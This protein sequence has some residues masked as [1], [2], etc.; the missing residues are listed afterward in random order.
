MHNKTSVVAYSVRGDNHLCSRHTCVCNQNLCDSNSCEV[1]QTKQIVHKDDK[2][3]GMGQHHATRKLNPQNTMEHS[4]K[5]VTNKKKSKLIVKIV[6]KIP[7][8]FHEI[9]L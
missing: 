3:T 5:N 9:K 1:W 8:R 7:V 6:E 4:M 2:H